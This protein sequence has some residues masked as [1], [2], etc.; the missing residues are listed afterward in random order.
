MLHQGRGPYAPRTSAYPVVTALPV[1]WLTNDN[2][3]YL[4]R[5]IQW[6]DCLCCLSVRLFAARRAQVRRGPERSTHTDLQRETHLSGVRRARRRALR[7]IRPDA[8]HRIFTGLRERL[9]W[10][11]LPAL[12]RRATV[13]C[14][15]VN[16]V[17]VVFAVMVENS[18][19]KQEL[20]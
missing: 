3:F 8:Y 14:P 19:I 15:V 9:L 2:C 20:N 18:S 5:R 6:N 4:W 17:P 1:V 12:F 11:H 10:P 7:G 13:L 16:S